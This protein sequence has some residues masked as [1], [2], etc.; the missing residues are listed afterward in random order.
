MIHLPRPPKVVGLQARA[1]APSQTSISFVKYQMML[2][3][4]T[5]DRVRRSCY[6]TQP[7]VQWHDHGPLPASTSWAQVILS[8]QPPGQLGLQRRGFTMLSRLVL[9][10]SIQ[11][12]HLPQPPKVLGLQIESCSVTQ[13]E[14]QW[15][16]LGSLQPLSAW[17]KQFSY[18]SLLISWDYWCAPSCPANF[19]ETRFHHVGQADLELLTSGDLLASASQSSGITA[20]LELLASS[21]PLTSASHNNGIIGKSHQAQPLNQGLALLS[22]LECSGM[23][24]AHCNLHLLGSSDSHGSVSQV[25]GITAMCHHAWLIFVFLVEMGF[26]HV[27]QAGLELLASSNPATSAS[28]SARITACMVLSVDK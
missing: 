13:A 20:G 6:V 12:V 22:N 23:I 28:Q 24:S 26:Y 27:G 3:A 10:S 17:F 18:L 2:L 7:H 25:A 9:N 16:D 15:R 14:V 11:V 4:C 21:D 8:P 1:I 19:L 5:K